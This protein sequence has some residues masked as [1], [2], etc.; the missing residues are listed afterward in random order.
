[1]QWRHLSILKSVSPKTPTLSIHSLA[2]TRN[3]YLPGCHDYIM[4]CAGVW[5]QNVCVYYSDHSMFS[6]YSSTA[7][8]YGQPWY[9]CM[10]RDRQGRQAKRRWAHIIALI[11][12]W[13]RNNSR[14]LSKQETSITYIELL[15]VMPSYANSWGIWV[16]LSRAQ[17][18]KT[19]QILISKNGVADPCISPELQKNRRQGIVKIKPK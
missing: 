13:E 14:T 19:R 3:S 9:L 16:L 17:S 12:I 2:H 10:G 4:I 8:L 11:K 6:I 15:M 5:A 1:M 18:Q 7:R